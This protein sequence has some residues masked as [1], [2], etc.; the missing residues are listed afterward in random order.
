MAVIDLTSFDAIPVIPW[1][2]L[3]DK[4]PCGQWKGETF[5]WS[6]KDYLTTLDRRQSEQMFHNEGIARFVCRACPFASPY[7]ATSAGPHWEFTVTLTDGSQIG[8][9]PPG[10]KGKLSWTSATDDAR[11]AALAAVAHKGVSEKVRACYFDTSRPR[12][13]PQGPTH[14]QFRPVDPNMLLGGHLQAAGAVVS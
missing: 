9:H 7:P 3:D 8:L 4:G 14:T 2:Y 13:N 10:R 1:E 12:S 11:A 6:W 5:D